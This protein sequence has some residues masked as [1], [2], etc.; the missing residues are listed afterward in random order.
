MDKISRTV[1][2]HLAQ[3]TVPPCQ[4]TCLRGSRR[5]NFAHIVYTDRTRP[6]ANTITALRTITT[7][8]IAVHS[9]GEAGRTTQ[10]AGGICTILRR[11]RITSSR[12]SIAASSAAYT[13]S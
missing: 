2:I 9:I 8:S 12:E 7:H 11:E 1:A 6:A 10:I 3:F 4:L 13:E 5:W